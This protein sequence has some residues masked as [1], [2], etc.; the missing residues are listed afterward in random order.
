L[1]LSQCDMVCQPSVDFGVAV[2]PGDWVVVGT[3][4]RTVGECAVEKV[5][6]GQGS[7]AMMRR[8]ERCEKRKRRVETL[9]N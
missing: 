7:E 3:G 8:A 5:E 6:D 4:W 2:I 9:G 1:V